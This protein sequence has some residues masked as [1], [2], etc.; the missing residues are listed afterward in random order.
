MSKQISSAKVTNKNK[1]KQ[2]A[3]TVLVK[4]NTISTQRQVTIPM[5][6]S[7]I[8]AGCCTIDATI[9]FLEAK[10]LISYMITFK[11]HCECECHL[12]EQDAQD[13]PDESHPNIMVEFLVV[14]Q[15]NGRRGRCQILVLWVF[16]ILI[17]EAWFLFLT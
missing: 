8:V 7:T 12:K 15:S 5:N 6:E 1:K 11:D 3:G 16:Q 14:K 9:G 17:E 13:F 2:L 4:L 10:R